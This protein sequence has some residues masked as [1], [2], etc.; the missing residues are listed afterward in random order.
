MDSKSEEYDE[1]EKYLKELREQRRRLE[2]E[3]LRVKYVG[4]QKE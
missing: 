3:R 2:Y 1:W 4:E